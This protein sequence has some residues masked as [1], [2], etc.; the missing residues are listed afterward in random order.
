MNDETAPLSAVRVEPV[1]GHVPVCTV[2]GGTY[3]GT[4]LEAVA[5]RLEKGDKVI[6]EGHEETVD[7][8]WFYAGPIIKL[9]SGGS[10][11]P[12]L[13]QKFELVPNATW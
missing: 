7:Y 4:E 1:V 10:V 6:F 2:D 13:G 8:V 12:A 9:E 11:F 5:A 3:H